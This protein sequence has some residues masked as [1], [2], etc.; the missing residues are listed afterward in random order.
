M[1]VI[2]NDGSITKLSPLELVWPLA[3]GSTLSA[4]VALAGLV[5]PCMSVGFCISCI[6]LAL[7][8]RDVKTRRACSSTACWRPVI[9]GSAGILLGFRR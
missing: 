7:F 6:P 8:P 5:N 3:W 1:V 9:A 2:S 4:A